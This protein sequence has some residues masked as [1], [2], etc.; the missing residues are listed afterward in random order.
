MATAALTFILTMMFLGIFISARKIMSRSTY[1]EVARKGDALNAIFLALATA[2]SIT[3]A[4][5]LVGP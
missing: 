1:R 5:L 2:M 4:K 3:M